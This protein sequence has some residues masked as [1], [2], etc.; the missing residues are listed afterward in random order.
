[1]MEA[2]CSSETSVLTRA[3]RRNLPEDGILHIH[4]RDNLKFYIFNNIAFACGE[5]GTSASD[6]DTIWASDLLLC[7]AEV[8]NKTPNTGKSLRLEAVYLILRSYYFLV[9]KN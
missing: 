4:R 1:M 9:L 6:V 5:V 3:T 7:Q 2:L 8:M